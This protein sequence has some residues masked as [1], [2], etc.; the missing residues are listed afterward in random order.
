VEVL[1]ALK[2]LT[3]TLHRKID[4]PLSLPV[5]AG[6]KEGVLA[7]LQGAG[8]GGGSCFWSSRKRVALLPP[9]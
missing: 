9:T 2:G 4:P 6:L 5:Y 3:L 1:E 7:G 8:E